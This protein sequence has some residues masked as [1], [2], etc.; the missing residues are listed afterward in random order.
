MVQTVKSLPAIQDTQVQ[1]LGREDLL[2]EG[3]A[4]HSTILAWRILWTEEPRRLQSMGPQ[5][6]Q[7][8]LT[9]TLTSDLND[10]KLL[11]VCGWWEKHTGCLPLELM[12]LCAPQDNFPG[13]QWE[14]NRFRAMSQE[15]SLLYAYNTQAHMCTKTGYQF[16][17]H[18]EL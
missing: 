17:G 14:R 16:S 6:R 3:M 8:W 13:V 10:S 2:E 15:H 9:N 11:T 4:T 5:K 12:L 7:M 18:K 1:F